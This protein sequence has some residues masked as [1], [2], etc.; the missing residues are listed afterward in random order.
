MTKYI[1]VYQEIYDSFDMV[2]NIF[3]YHL[4]RSTM[5]INPVRRHSNYQLKVYMYMSIYQIRM[6]RVLTSHAV[7]C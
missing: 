1:V 5:N 3:L 2:M 6:S 4:F 7:T